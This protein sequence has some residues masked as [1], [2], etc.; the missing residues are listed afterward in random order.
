MC[1]QIAVICSADFAKRIKI[2][3]NELPSIKL[4]YY[5]YKKPQEAPTL[6]SQIKPC[7]AV[8]FSGALPYYYAKKICEGLPIPTHYLQQDETAIATTLLAIT[9]RDGISL[10]EV[11]IDITDSQIVTSVLE[12]IGLVLTPKIFKFDPT[13]NIQELVEFHYHLYKNHKTLHAITSVHAVYEILQELNVPVS[14]MIDPRSSIIKGIVDTKNL[15][16]LSKSQSAKIAVGFIKFEGIKEIH[17]NVLS[18]FTELFKTKLI[19]VESNSY[20]IFSTQGDVEKTFEFITEEKW[21]S[22]IDTPFKLAFGYGSHI[23]EATQN[24]KDALL[25]TKTNTA[26]IITEKKQLLGP[27]PKYHHCIELRTRE[28]VLVEVAKSTSLSPA[29]LSKVIQFSKYHS[30]N[31]F[32][33][34]DLETF[35][36]VSRRTSER[37]LKKLVDHHYAEIIGEEMTYQQGRPRA[38]YKLN[39]PTYT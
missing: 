30:A 37:I 13:T 23:E 1:T 3:E 24:A 33:A 29:N 16:I 22:L 27:Y 12:D 25:L 10:Q 39:I 9:K 15:A 6:I 5:L 17:S 28:P 21:K 18:R 8:F 2:I 7:D 20:T 26:N 32:T 34:H 14:G 35:L 31:E 36:K 4:Q 38:V 11:S 19:S